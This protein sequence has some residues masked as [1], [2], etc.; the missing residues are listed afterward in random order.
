MRDYDVLDVKRQSSLARERGAAR[1]MT[2]L[3]S[4]SALFPYAVHARVFE[5]FADVVQERACEQSIAVGMHLRNI[6]VHFA[7]RGGDRERGLRDRARMCKKTRRAGNVLNSG[8]IAGIFAFS[9]SKSG[10]A[11]SYLLS[12]GK[13]R[14][15]GP[16]YE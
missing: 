2:Q 15:A 5:H 6:G 12:V 16:A 7:Q 9:R 11:R 3:A 14:A 13:S 4:T 10:I 1:G 8:R